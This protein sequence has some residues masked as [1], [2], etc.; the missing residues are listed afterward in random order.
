MLAM[1]RT[2]S[3]MGRFSVVLKAQ[4]EAEYIDMVL[5]ATADARHNVH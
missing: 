1:M 5:E 2:G 3:D 4:N